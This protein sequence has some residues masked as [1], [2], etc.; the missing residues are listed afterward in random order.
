MTPQL[1]GGLTFPAIAISLLLLSVALFGTSA[2]AASFVWL[3]GTGLQGVLSLAV[4][5]AWIG[6]RPL[7]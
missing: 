4:I 5:G 1:K 2:E 6:H 7:S 3:A